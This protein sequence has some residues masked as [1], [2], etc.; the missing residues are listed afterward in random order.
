[1][2]Q[3]KERAKEFFFFFKVDVVRSDTQCQKDGA[4]LRNSLQYLILILDL[5]C[6][7]RFFPAMLCVLVWGAKYK[8]ASMNEMLCADDRSS[9]DLSV[10]RL[11]SNVMILYTGCETK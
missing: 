11:R 6:F 4:R 3:K 2:K 1:M 10:F 7:I 5:G 8:C 9:V